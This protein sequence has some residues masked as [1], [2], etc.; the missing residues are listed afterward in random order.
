MSFISDASNF[1]L[2]EGVY[3]NINGNVYNFY[4]TKCNASYPLLSAPPEEDRNQPELKNEIKV[5]KVSFGIESSMRTFWQIIRSENLK[6]FCEIGGGPGYLL[7]AGQNSGRAVI[8]KVFNPGPGPTVLK[9]LKRLQ[10]TVSLSK[11]ILHP[12][13]LRLYGISPPESSFHFIV[14]ENV[15][16]K[17]AAGPLAA[18]LKADLTRS[19]TLGFKMIAGL[20]A[21]MDHLYIQG[22][23]L[24]FMGVDNFDIFLDVNDRFLLSINP[25]ASEQ[26]GDTYER[27]QLQEDEAWMVLNALC[28]KVLMSANWVL[29]NEQIDRHPS[30]PDT[31]RSSSVSDIP[32]T[33]LLPLESTTTPQSIQTDAPPVA[34]RREYVWRTKDRGRQSLGMVAKRIT[35]DLDVNLSPVHRFTR[36]DGRNPHR[37]PGYIRE[38]V[39]LAMTILDSAVVAHDTPSPLETCSICHEVVGLDEVFRCVCGATDPGSR[40]TIKCRVCKLW[41]HNDCVGNPKEFT[42]QV[43]LRPPDMTG[44]G[45]SAAKPCDH[46]GLDM[47]DI[48]GLAAADDSRLNAGAEPRT[49]SRSQKKLNSGTLSL[50]SFRDIRFAV[51][52]MSRRA[53]NKRTKHNPVPGPYSTWLEDVGY[54]FGWV[55]SYEDRPQGLQWTSVVYVNK[56]NCGRGSGRSKESARD[57]AAREAQMRMPMYDPKGWPSAK[58]ATSTLLLG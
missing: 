10:L 51:P 17:N 33:S 28:Q 18:A 45:S 27:P 39:T 44:P 37:C 13:V 26:E 35:L 29:H 53:P 6:L 8:V 47:K 14:Y 3:T 4:D 32:M 54:R 11:R 57:S 9:V 46:L 16:W 56:S 34:S 50:D 22:I 15:H 7:H 38:E 36:S 12:N 40:H 31:L 30:I 52:R 41:S 55:I 42:C 21:G 2:G 1:T 24:R 5:C 25:W 19:I 48:V 58:S 43:C 20:S 49:V 23:S